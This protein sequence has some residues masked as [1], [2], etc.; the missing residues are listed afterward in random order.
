VRAHP[1]RKPDGAEGE[2]DHRGD[3]ERQHRGALGSPP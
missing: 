3:E 2:H 1:E